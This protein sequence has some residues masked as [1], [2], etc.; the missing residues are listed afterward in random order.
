MKRLGMN[1]PDAEIFDFMAYNM[2]T[3]LNSLIL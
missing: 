1:L 2:N 3:P